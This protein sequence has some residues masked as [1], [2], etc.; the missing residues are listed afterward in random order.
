MTT[1][2]T[3]ITTT[4]TIII[5]MMI[6]Q[7]VREVVLHLRMGQ[8]M[9][10]CATF[11]KH[12]LLTLHCTSP[13]QARTIHMGRAPSPCPNSQLQG[14]A[15]NIVPRMQHHVSAVGGNEDLCWVSAA[16]LQ[17]MAEPDTLQ[18]YSTWHGRSSWHWCSWPPSTATTM[19]RAWDHVTPRM[20]DV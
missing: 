6:M 1:S 18:S 20:A 2:S 13:T 10:D 3:C 16:G 4:T 12:G 8:V 7:G 15:I 17:P 19:Q 14:P 5:I 11:G 9:P